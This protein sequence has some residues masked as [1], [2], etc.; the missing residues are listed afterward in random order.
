MKEYINKNWTPLV[1]GFAIAMI[2]N[3]VLSTSESIILKIA[4]I[5]AR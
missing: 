2:Y 1:I 3:A 5:N 4:I